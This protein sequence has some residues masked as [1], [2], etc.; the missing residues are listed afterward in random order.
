MKPQYYITHEL[1]FN[2]WRAKRVQGTIFAVASETDYVPS[3]PCGRDREYLANWLKESGI[4]APYC[5]AVANQSQ[6]HIT[7]DKFQ[8]RLIG[9]APSTGSFC[10]V[11]DSQVAHMPF[12]L[13]IASPDLNYIQMANG[14][15]FIE[16]IAYGFELCGSYTTPECDKHNPR[17]FPALTTPSQLE[18]YACAIRGTHGVKT[19]RRAARHVLANAAS[20]KETEVAIMLTLPHRFHGMGMMEPQ[21]NYPIQIDRTGKS[22][23]SQNRFFIDMYWPDYR[24]GLEIDSNRY[25]DG[26]ARRIKDA[27]RRNALMHYGITIVEGTQG[28]TGNALGMT[29][30]AKQLYHLMG[31]KPRPGQFDLTPETLELYDEISRLSRRP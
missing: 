27:R 24:I 19:A 5:F 3:F 28:D 21:L 7:D 31:A 2:T 17:S 9:K 1:A 23:I 30:L 20:I 26:R 10:R 14:F 29:G 8:P 15:T 4:G 13:F 18:A 11:V 25:H 12:D 22:F 6:R 16:T